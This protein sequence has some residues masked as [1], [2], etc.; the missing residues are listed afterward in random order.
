MD[1]LSYERT[2]LQIALPLSLPAIATVTVLQVIQW[3]QTPLHHASRLQDTSAAPIRFSPM[4]GCGNQPRDVRPTGSWS[5][6]L[7]CGQRHYDRPERAAEFGQQLL[8][9]HRV[10]LVRAPLQQPGDDVA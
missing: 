7:T 9:T 2:F 10:G 3:R 8:M 4:S 1:G 6:A 5:E